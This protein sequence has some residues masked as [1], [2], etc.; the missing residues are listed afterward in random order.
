MNTDGRLDARVPVRKGD[1]L[2]AGLQVRATG[3]DAR[4][5]RLKGAGDNLLAIGVESR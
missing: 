3:N 1:V 2:D 5:S 4:N